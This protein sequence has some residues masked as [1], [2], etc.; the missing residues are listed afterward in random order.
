[1]IVAKQ[2]YMLAED[3]NEVMDA[4]RDKDFGREY[5]DRYES[6]VRAV[7]KEKIPIEILPRIRYTWRPS[8]WKSRLLKIIR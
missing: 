8:R 2:N 4:F 1:M 5:I 3:I 6:V 7:R